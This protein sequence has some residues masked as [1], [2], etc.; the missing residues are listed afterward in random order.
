M[1]LGPFGRG[2]HQ[3]GLRTHLGHGI[4]ALDLGFCC[5]GTQAGLELVTLLGLQVPGT[6]NIYTL[7]LTRQRFV[8]L[9]YAVTFSLQIL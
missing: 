2:A 6:M 4:K 9:M 7:L 3:S 1:Q 5:Y 8:G